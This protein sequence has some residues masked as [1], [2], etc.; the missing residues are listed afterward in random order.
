M[1][2]KLLRIQHLN[3]SYHKEQI[4][5]DIDLSLEPGLYALL[6]PNGAGKT[7]FLK[8]LAGILKPVSGE[9]YY[10]GN[11][12]NA[13]RQTYLLH[14]GYLPQDLGLIPEY[15]V[16]Q[17]LQFMASLKAVRP[18]VFNRRIRQWL[19]FFHIRQYQ[20]AKIKSLSV[21]TQQKIGIIQAMLN[22]PDMLLLDEPNAW[23]DPKERANFLMVLSELSKSRVIF[24]SSHMIEDIARIPCQI[25][26]LNQHRIICNRSLAE[27]TQELGSARTL[28]QFYLDSIQA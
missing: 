22:D 16:E 8:L 1:K 24:L 27:I 10:Q 23:M 25:L 20:S 11:N 19:D 21:G 14:L 13:L 4:L 9:I 17:Y 15:T 5:T 3:F 6:G 7:T 12:I 26:I 18:I 2:D 28:E